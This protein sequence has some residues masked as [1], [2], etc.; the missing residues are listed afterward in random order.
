MESFIKVAASIPSLKVADVFYNA[1]QIVMLCKK[2][3]KTGVQ[4]ISFPETCLTGYT[5]GDLFLQSTLLNKTEEALSYILK[6]TKKLDLIIIL[7]APVNAGAQ[8]A[9]CA[10]V[11]CKGKILGAVPKTYLPNYKE[12]YEKRYFTPATNLLQEK[13]TLCGQDI[14]LSTKLLFKAGMALFACE[15]CEDLW[16]PLS[17]SSLAVLNGAN[18]IFNLSGSDELVGKNEY[19]KNLL[20]VHS[21][22]NICA[23]VYASSG[24]GESTTDSAYTGNAFIYENG[25]CLAQAKRFSTKEQLIISDIDTEKLNKLR[26]QNIT[27]SDTAANYKMPY[28]II[29]TKLKLKKNSLNRSFNPLPFVPQDKKY[30]DDILNI[31]VFGLAK[32]LIHTNAKTLVLGISGG[33]DSAWALIVCAHTLKLLGRTNKDILAITMPAFATSKRTRANAL[34]LAKA[35]GATT[36]E[37][38]IS[39]TCL[40]QLK[41]IK[42]SPKKHDITFENT[43]ARYRTQI[44]MNFANQTGGIVIGTGDLSELALGWCTYNGDHMSMYGVNAGLSKTLIKALTLNYAQNSS[45][46]IAKLLKDILDTPISPEL[47]PA[48]KKGTQQTE[49]S[50]GP[51]ELHD[52]FL[53][54]FMRYN[55][56]PKK[57]FFM[58]ENAF[59]NKYTKIELKKYLGIFFKRFFSQQFKRSCLPDGVKVC[60]FALSPRGDWRMPSDASLCAWQKELEE[61]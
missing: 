18:I 7:G 33:L 14:P 19:R 24:I 35:F 22:K 1:E 44:L 25:A 60:A 45:S 28:T 4:V 26:H 59:K 34:A 38:N 54:Y 21:T 55:F 42:H 20:S 12:F 23:Y 2:A 30:F 58:A 43:Q 61:I 6:E 40:S 50:I 32:R 13:I 11:V 49:L 39:A 47:V 36:K 52:F 17:P 8:L 46:K 16:A 51:Y 41:D 56:G 48:T 31:Q 10:L 15:I 37:I 5:C 57:I 27:F 3:A 53:Y 29:D 9:N